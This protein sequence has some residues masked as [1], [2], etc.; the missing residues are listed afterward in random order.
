[1][2]VNYVKRKNRPKIVVP[3]HWTIERAEKSDEDSN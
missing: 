2:L 3:V 1:M